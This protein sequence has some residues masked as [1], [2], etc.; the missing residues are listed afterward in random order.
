MVSG[1]AA[2]FRI[3]ASRLGAP[4]QCEPF[5]QLLKEGGPSK[6]EV[7]KLGTREAEAGRRLGG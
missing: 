2:S 6:E 7:G 1:S 5:S 4:G 3:W